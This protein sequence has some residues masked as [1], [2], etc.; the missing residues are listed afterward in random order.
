[1]NKTKDLI[2]KTAF[3]LFKEKGYDNVSVNDICSACGITKPTFYYHIKSKSD[4]F[5]LQFDSITDVLI[6]YYQQS[7]DKGNYWE[8]LLLLY[9]LIIQD[10]I[11]ENID[12]YKQM[13][14]ANLRSDI[15]FCDFNEVLTALGSSLVEKAQSAGQIRNQCPPQELYKAM[16]FAYMGNEIAWCIKNGDFDHIQQ[17]HNILEVICDVA[18]EY[19]T[20]ADSPLLFWFRKTTEKT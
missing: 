1:M 7:G 13:M 11:G 19:R 14:I 3:A 2:L 4:I 12:L 17:L 5:P 15:G 9:D 6:K 16:G 20:A 10:G 8:Q 18:P